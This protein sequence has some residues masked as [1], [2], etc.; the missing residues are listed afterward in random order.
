MII[1]RKPS[2]LSYLVRDDE[3]KLSEVLVPLQ[4]YFACSIHTITNS[5]LLLLPFLDRVFKEM[6]V[7]EGQNRKVARNITTLVEWDDGD[8]PS[9]MIMFI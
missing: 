6:E 2:Y 7:M 9:F 1:R 8:T 4:S 5:L 3:M